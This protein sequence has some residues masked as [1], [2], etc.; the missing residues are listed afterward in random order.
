MSRFWVLAAIGFS[1]FVFRR[2]KH[3]EVNESSP[4]P[5]SFGSS[6]ELSKNSGALQKGLRLVVTADDLGY[7]TERDQ[8]IIQ[9]FENGIVTAASL[10]AGFP[11]SQEAINRAASAESRWSGGLPRKLDLGLHLNLTEGKALTTG[12]NFLGKLGFWDIAAPAGCANGGQAHPQASAAFLEKEIRAQVEWFVQHVGHPPSH[13]DGHNHVHVIPAVARVLAKV[14][15]EVGVKWTR[16]PRENLASVVW[17]SEAQKGFYE[18]VCQCSGESAGIFRGCGVQT[19]QGF[20][21][22]RSVSEPQ[23]ILAGLNDLPADISL[24]EFMVHPG[25]PSASGDEFSR[26]SDRL[27]ELNCLTSA[28]T[29]QLVQTLCVKLVAFSDL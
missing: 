19:T 24:A 9:A 7:A 11:S 4:L 12:E 10:L 26:S 20:V 23:H 14:M 22:F 13:I 16:M 25:F 21:G 29:K 18:R 2:K 6:S 8:G 17:A 28:T 5:P 15:A 1:W 3:A 27:A